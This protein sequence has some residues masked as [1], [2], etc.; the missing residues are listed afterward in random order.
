MKKNKLIVLYD[1]ECG[2]C[3]K[4][5]AIINRIDIFNQLELLTVQD[6]YYK[7]DS[8]D[9]DKMLEE[10]HCLDSNGNIYSGYDSYVHILIS[11]LYTAPLGVIIS[12]PVI[13][14]VGAWVYRIVAE[15]RQTS[16]CASGTCSFKGKGGRVV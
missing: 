12:L 1:G 2:L 7:Y 4:T 16:R 9:K 5:A 15:R 8:L 14:H 11:M 13:S 3:L 10:M 6:N